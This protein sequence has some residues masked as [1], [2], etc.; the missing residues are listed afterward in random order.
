MEGQLRVATF[1]AA[2]QYPC[3]LFADVE[4][5]SWNQALSADV[6]A[7]SGDSFWQVNAEIGYRSP[8]RHVQVS[9]GLLNLTGQNYHLFPINLYPDLP[10]QSM[11]VTR[12]QLNF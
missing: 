2:F 9:V 4:A 6:A 11:F 7:L 1:D 10:R 12:L 3:G 5:Q 8:R